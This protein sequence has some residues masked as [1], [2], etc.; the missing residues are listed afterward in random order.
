MNKL[1]ALAI[2]TLG[3]AVGTMATYK[4]LKRRYEMLLNENEDTSED[5]DIFDNENLNDRKEE[6]SNKEKAYRNLNKPSI[7]E[8]IKKDDE[9]EDEEDMDNY[10]NLIDDEEYEKRDE[11]YIISP[12][13]IGERELY[14]II[15]LKLYENGVLTDDFDE[16]VIDV[17]S[18]VG[19][20]Y[21]NHFGEYNQPDMVVVRNDR[22]KA[23]FEICK[24]IG[25]FILDE[26]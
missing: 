19:L 21:V 8:Y 4:F 1:K 17:K 13:D 16:P 18:T 25:D 20:D 2:F 23:D 6:E 15:S 10:V 11:P 14:D 26:D 22:L 9:D 7:S 24:V 3:V 12:D 5:D